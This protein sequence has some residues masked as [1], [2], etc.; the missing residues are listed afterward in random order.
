MY[1]TWTFPSSNGAER[2]GFDNNGYTTW[3][4]CNFFP[5]YLFFPRSA[6]L[7]AT[8]IGTALEHLFLPRSAEQSGTVMTMMGQCSGAISIPVA[9]S[10]TGKDEM[11]KRPVF[12]GVIHHCSTERNGERCTGERM[13]VFWGVIRHCS[14]ERNG[15]R[16]TGERMPVF[17]G[18]I[19]HCSTERNGAGKRWNAQGT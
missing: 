10:R 14:T 8:M 7:C 11:Y 12:W 4:T 17:W 2:N 15:E 18:V 5:S 16:C 1:S 6:P 19:R 3:T 9:R 13:P